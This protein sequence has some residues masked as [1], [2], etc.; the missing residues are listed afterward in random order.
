MEQVASRSA[1]RAICTAFFRFLQDDPRFYYDDAAALL[2]GYRRS[3]EETS[4]RACRGCSRIF[5]RRTT[6]CAPS[7]VPRAVRRG[8][9]LSAAVGR[10]LAPGHLLRQH[11]QPEGAAEVRHGDAV[12]ARSGAGHHFQIA[13]QQEL[14]RSAALPPLRRRLRRLRGRL[15]ALRGIDRQGAGPVHRSVPVL[16]PPERRDA[17]RDAAGRRHRPAHARAGAAS[18][19]SATCSTTHRWRRAT[20]T[21]RSSATSRFR[22]RRSATRSASCASASCA[23]RRENALGARFDVKRIPQPGAARRRAADGCAGD[24]DRSVDRGAAARRRRQ[25]QEER[26]MRF[27]PNRPV[28][29]VSALAACSR[30]AE[31]AEQG[32]AQ[33]AHAP[34]NCRPSST[35]LV[36]EYYEKFLELNPLPAPSSTTIATTTASRTTSGRTIS[37]SRSRSRRSISTSAGARSRDAHGPGPP[38]LRHLPA[39]PA[40]GDRGPRVSRR[41]D[42]REP[43]LQPAE[44]LRRARLR[45][46]RAALHD[47]EEYRRLPR[48]RR[49]LRDLDGPGDREHA[50]RASSAASCSRA[51]SSSGRSRSSRRTSWTTGRRASSHRPIETMPESITAEQRAELTAAY[52]QSITGTI[53]PAYRRLRDYLR[54]EYLPKHARHRGPERAAARAPPGTRI[55]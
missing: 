48:P 33:A 45:L 1:S 50:R 23:T 38:H 37:R 52:E 55:S 28:L 36:E 53:V 54:D 41:A 17:A 7:S 49:G 11:V 5:P 10:R 46:E 51:S 35:Q 16:R 34:S 4:M 22:A 26:T 24:E 25:C 18:R 40:H 6:K 47:Y 19:R 3:E 30:G 32:A 9:L 20:S 15:G 43:V 44:L 27:Q 8:R 42:A 13:I 29:I 2:Q 31:E 12:A 14:D 21:R 39:R